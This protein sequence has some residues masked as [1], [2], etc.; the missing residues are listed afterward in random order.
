MR[1]LTNSVVTALVAA[2]SALW[3]TP[4]AFGAGAPVR[5]LGTP[6]TII[7]TSGDDHLVGTRSADVIVGGAGVD[8]I[9]G[10]GGND[11]ICEG[12]TPRALD[13]EGHP[14]SSLLVGGPG[15]DVL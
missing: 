11:L 3:I 5:C 12:P 14:R 13:I 6:A 8:E 4:T 15:N 2:G 7:G 10:A 9:D 1:T